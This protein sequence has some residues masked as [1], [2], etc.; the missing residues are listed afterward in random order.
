ML[1]LGGWVKALH[2]CSAN[3]CHGAENGPSNNILVFI[4]KLQLAVLAT[5]TGDNMQAVYH[6]FFSLAVATPFVTACANVKLLFEKVG[7]EHT[8]PLLPT[9]D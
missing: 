8:F 6:Y 3:C 9:V 4:V 2:A 7:N 5:Y 1:F